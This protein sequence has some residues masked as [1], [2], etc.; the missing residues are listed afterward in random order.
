MMYSE[1]RDEI[2]LWMICYIIPKFQENKMVIWTK[3]MM[4]FISNC[5]ALIQ[6]L[7]SR[8]WWCKAQL[9]KT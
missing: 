9:H 5:W 2:F 7:W 6:S 8:P 1:F 3:L 4:E